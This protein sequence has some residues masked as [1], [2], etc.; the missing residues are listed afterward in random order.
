VTT[1]AGDEFCPQFLPANGS[2]SAPIELQRSGGTIPTPVAAA[3]AISFGASSAARNYELINLLPRSRHVRYPKH[4]VCQ[5][6]PIPSP[7]HAPE[8]YGYAARAMRR[9]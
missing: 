5:C 6:S 3:P 8:A 2:F 9:S 4:R 7:T 1:V